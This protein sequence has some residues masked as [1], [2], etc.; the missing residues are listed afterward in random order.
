MKNP[1]R[2]NSISRWYYFRIPPQRMGESLASVWLGKWWG[3]ENIWFTKCP[4]TSIHH[5]FLTFVSQRLFRD[6]ETQNAIII[7]RIAASIVGNN[8]ADYSLPLPLN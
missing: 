6:E 1:L 2:R 4:R 3:H 7:S 5:G 8:E